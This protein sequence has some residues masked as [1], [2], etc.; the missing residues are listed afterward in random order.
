MAFI[1]EVAT[2]EEWQKYAEGWCPRCLGLCTCRA[3]MRKPHART[4]YSGPAHQTEEFAR[5]VLRYVGPLLADQ[6]RDKN[7][8]VCITPFCGIK[9]ERAQPRC[10]NG[11]VLA[12]DWLPLALSCV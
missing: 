6:Q 4:A 7:S 3:C 12:A 9:V 2:D 5:H 1:Q 8:E 10:C 11:S